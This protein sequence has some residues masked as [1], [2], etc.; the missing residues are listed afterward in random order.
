M[1][2]SL[3]CLISIPSNS[4]GKTWKMNINGLENVRGEVLESCGR[5]LSLFCTHHEVVKVG[6]FFS[7]KTY[8][9]TILLWIFLLEFLYIM[10]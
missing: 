4:T 1:Y 10:L 5:P 8:K 7:S 3:T 6:I 9:F 2:D